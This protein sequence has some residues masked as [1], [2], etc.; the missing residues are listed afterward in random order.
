MLNRIIRSSSGQI[1][2]L[3]I[4]EELKDVDLKAAFTVL[5]KSFARKPTQMVIFEMNNVQVLSQESLDLLRRLVRLFQSKSVSVAFSGT[6]LLEPRVLIEIT[7]G[8][9]VF[10]SSLQA[11]AFFM[12]QTGAE[13][14]VVHPQKNLH[15]VLP[16]QNA[17]DL[18][19][20]QAE[21]P[22]E[23]VG[24]PYIKKEWGKEPE[25][26]EP[27]VQE[28]L[29]DDEN[30][31]I[32]SGVGLVVDN[33]GTV[34]EQNSDSHAFAVSEPELLPEEENSGSENGSAA[35][36]RTVSDVWDEKL[37]AYRAGCLLLLALVIVSCAIII[38]IQPFV[39]L[40]ALHD[41]FIHYSQAGISESDT[42]NVQVLQD[43]VH[44][45]WIWAAL[46]NGNLVQVRKLLAAGLNIEV[47][48]R[49]GHSPLMKAVVHGNPELVRI[50]VQHGARVNV[51]DELGDTPLVW[52]A[53]KDQ[54][55]VVRI[56]LDHGADPDRGIFTAMMWAALHGNLE[57]VVLLLQSG[58]D[59][60][61]RSREGWSALMWASEKGHSS[62][63]EHL[64]TSGVSINAQ[65]REGYTALMLAVRRGRESVAKI[66][67]KYGADRSISGLDRKTALDL[68][69]QFKRMHLIPLLV[70]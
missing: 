61:L 58:G 63:V 31:S 6:G 37:F 14:T 48:D 50:L 13:N 57:M 36:S 11:E 46:E 60:D 23:D 26:E 33:A 55:E 56:L 38:R 44:S 5:E 43:P 25:K 69:R 4:Q 29:N 12:K 1:D 35:V 7:Q 22:S 20:N 42:G 64:L 52:A 3:S 45:G 2:T 16:S 70:R 28:F 68:A 32:Q 47:R 8:N 67:L 41:L 30:K 19:S 54:L 27:Y 40:G 59:P 65:N 15:G 39:R 24:E 51:S 17:D 21:R 34:H 66:L 10:E 53:S 49:Q 18:F 9:P 62:V